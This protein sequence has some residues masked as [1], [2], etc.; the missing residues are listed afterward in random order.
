VSERG[1]DGEGEEEEEDEEVAMAHLN[2]CLH[3]VAVATE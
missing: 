1:W 2:G 3:F